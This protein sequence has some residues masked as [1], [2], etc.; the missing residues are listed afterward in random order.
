M[1]VCAFARSALTS[2]FTKTAAAIST[3][4]MSLNWVQ[5]QQMILNF[6]FA[7]VP[8]AFSQ[9]TSFSKMKTM[10]LLWFCWLAFFLCT[11]YIV[12]V[13]LF[14]YIVVTYIYIYI[15][16]YIYTC[17]YV[18]VFPSSISC[19][20]Y[21]VCMYIKKCIVFWLKASRH[22]IFYDKHF[23]AHD[24]QDGILQFSNANLCYF[25]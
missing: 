20:S 23:H 7:D 15:Y 11:M 24:L 25:R 1:M 18:Y 21:S 5:V 19:I 8:Y 3:Q 17:I 10:L 16:I 2:G 9:K 13:Y 12:H 22:L 14:T 4:H 6:Q